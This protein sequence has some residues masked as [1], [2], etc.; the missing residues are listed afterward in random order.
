MF[1]LCCTK[2]LLEL[3]GIEVTVESVKWTGLAVQDWHDD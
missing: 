2:G 1:D 3:H